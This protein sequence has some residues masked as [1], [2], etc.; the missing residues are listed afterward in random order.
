MKKLT[1][2]AIALLL[3]LPGIAAVYNPLKVGT[4]LNLPG[5]LTN[6]GQAAQ[7]ILEPTGYKL[8]VPNEAQ[9]DTLAILNRPVSPVAVKYGFTTIENA[10]LVLI[11][12]DARIVVDR[13]HKLITFEMMPGSPR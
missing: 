6:V 1:L 2:L 9:Q 3:P 12:S 5:E 13:E 4:S 7:Y 11:G 8:V 10:L